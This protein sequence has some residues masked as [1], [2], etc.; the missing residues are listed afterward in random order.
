MAASADVAWVLESVGVGRF[1]PAGQ[2]V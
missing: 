2:R 1:Q